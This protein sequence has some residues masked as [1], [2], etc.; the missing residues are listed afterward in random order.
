MIVRFFVSK[1]SF[2]FKVKVVSEYLENHDSMNGLSKKY[3]INISIIR[4]WIHQ[5]EQNGLSSLQVKHSKRVYSPDFKIDVVRYYLNN[6]NL[7]ELPVATKFNIHSSKV[8][9]WVKKFK[10]EGIAGLLPKQK[11]RP[12]RM[13]KKIKY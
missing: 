10:H 1:Y 7:G 2:D 12:S 8:F 6:P 13:S 5:A 9:S 3:K 11:G 4:K